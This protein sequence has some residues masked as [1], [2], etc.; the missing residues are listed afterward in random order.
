MELIILL[1][2]ENVQMLDKYNLRNPSKGTLY[3]A[4]THLIFVDHE[5]RKETW[6]SVYL[7]INFKQAFTCPPAYPKW[8][9]ARF[10]HHSLKNS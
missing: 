8:E 5:M 7:Y 2:L 3:F 4:T 9:K 1:Q 6:V 10:G